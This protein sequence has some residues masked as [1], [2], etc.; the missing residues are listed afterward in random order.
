ME[1]IW[2]LYTFFAVALYVTHR[3]SYKAAVRATMVDTVVLIEQGNLTYTCE[4]DDEG[5][6]DVAITVK[7]DED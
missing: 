1:Y 7:E 2:I 3:V 6:F 5:F 4:E